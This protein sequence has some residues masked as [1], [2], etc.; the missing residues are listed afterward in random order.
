MTTIT[1][2]QNLLSKFETANKERGTK[3][4]RKHL[5]AAKSNLRV[6]EQCGDNPDLTV[7]KAQ[8]LRQA[9]GE[10]TA[11]WSKLRSAD[12]PAPKSQRKRGTR[13][14]GRKIK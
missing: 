9:Q 5:K 7:R 6:A 3:A 2:T 12:E 11:G 8:A 14:K 13:G 4:S 1:E 10:I